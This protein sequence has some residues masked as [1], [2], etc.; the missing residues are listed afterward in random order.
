MKIGKIASYIS[1]GIITIACGKG[2]YTPT[3]VKAEKMAAKHLK[4]T[5]FVQLQRTMPALKD[6]GEYTEAE[7]TIHYWDSLLCVN[8]MKAV[9]FLLVFNRLYRVL[10]V[11]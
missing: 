9:S 6:I 10:T 2:T 7:R 3:W 8:K 1:A 5:E 4:G 11:V